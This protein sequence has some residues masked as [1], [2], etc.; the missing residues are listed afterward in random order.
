MRTVTAVAVAPLAVVPVLA[1]LFGPWAIANGGW[2][3]WLGIAGPAL[4]VAYPLVV[5]CGLPM[6]AALTRARCT[7]RRDYAIAG[8]LLGSVPVV[9]YVLVAVAF[10][11]KFVLPAMG[12]ALARNVEWGAIGVAVFGLCTIAVALTFRAIA[13]NR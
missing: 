9:G 5:L 6:H 11:A 2:R 12:R 1:V 3:T 10:E 13:L 7:R 8:A 4:L